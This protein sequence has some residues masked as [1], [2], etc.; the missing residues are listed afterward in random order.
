MHREATNYEIFQCVDRG[1]S[2]IGSSVAHV[3]YWRLLETYDFKPTDIAAD[4]EVL[5]KALLEIFGSGAVLLGRAI[6][7]ELATKF[8]M[9]W[10][11]L[12]SFAE[13]VN[14]ILNRVKYWRPE[15]Y[16]TMQKSR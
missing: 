16:P 7:R 10:K 14:E 3:T 8:Q 12:P 9:A 6:V 1:L 13:A 2:S 4:P 11:K 5:S 15:E